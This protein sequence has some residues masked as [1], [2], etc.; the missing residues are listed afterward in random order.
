MKLS[1]TDVVTA[2]ERLTVRRLRLW[3]RRG[4]VSPRTDENGP[5]FDEIDVARARLICE[6]T[7]ELN[8]NDDA[9]PVVLS[10]MDQLHNVRRELKSLVSALEHEPE[11]IRRRV[12]DAY[13]RSRLG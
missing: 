9:V 10:L 13:R 12:R 4:W 11:D 3:V 5:R 7:D 1:E 8:L 2:V 6:F